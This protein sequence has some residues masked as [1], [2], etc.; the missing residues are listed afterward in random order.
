[1]ARN[2]LLRRIARQKG[3]QVPKIRDALGE[4]VVVQS[5]QAVVSRASAMLLE[6]RWRITLAGEPPAMA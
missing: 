1:M 3:P 4:C 6:N 2:V 5:H